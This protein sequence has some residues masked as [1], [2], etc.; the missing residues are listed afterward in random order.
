MDW[1][2]LSLILFLIILGYTTVNTL[3]KLE[4]CEDIIL[5]QDEYI[6][7]IQESIIFSQKKIKEIDEKET[8]KSDDEIGWFFDNIKQIQELISSYKIDK[9]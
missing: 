6:S 2:I 5:S 7:K 3:R 1:L 9:K 8:F 4:K